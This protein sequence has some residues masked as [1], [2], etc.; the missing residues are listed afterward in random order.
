[1]AAKKIDDPDT[2]TREVL[3]RKET[4]EEV[5]QHERLRDTDPG[6][7]GVP[8]TDIDEL[9]GKHGAELEQKIEI[10][11]EIETETKT[12]VNNRPH[13][14][15]QQL[16]VTAL[17]AIEKM[18]D[19]SR[20]QSSA[21]LYLRGLIAQLHVEFFKALERAAASGED[22]EEI[23]MH[24]S[25]LQDRLQHTI[26]Y[27]MRRFN[28]PIR[29]EW[30]ESSKRYSSIS[31]GSENVEI[32]TRWQSWE[33]VQAWK[34]AVDYLIFEHEGFPGK[35]V[36]KGPEG[37]CPL[38][39]EVHSRPQT[40]NGWST[41]ISPIYGIGSCVPHAIHR[42]VLKIQE[43]G[44]DEDEQFGLH[45]AQWVDLYAKIRELDRLFDATYERP[46]GGK[47]LES[48][49]ARIDKDW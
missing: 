26:V 1:M 32:F 21:G 30:Q 8:D 4:G 38:V 17:E 19:S 43:N 31:W 16:I 9:V 47:D 11:I 36:R 41:Y 37:Y 35:R 20:I 46:E 27:A 34:K 23:A 28:F 6:I 22:S 2:G 33:Q 12:E 10:E 24:R 39:D 14:N 7:A 13:T 49:G 5:L 18:M 25:T 15:S 42:L 45:R 29:S 40:E 48:L 3:K 44:E